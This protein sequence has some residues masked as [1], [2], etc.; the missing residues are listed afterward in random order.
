MRQNERWH[1]LFVCSVLF[2]F[3]GALNET[4]VKRNVCAYFWQAHVLFHVPCPMF[5][6]SVFLFQRF[7]VSRLPFEHPPVVVATKGTTGDLSMAASLR[8]TVMCASSL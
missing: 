5:Q 2:C 4:R 1:M 6:C 8:V 7:L 3:G